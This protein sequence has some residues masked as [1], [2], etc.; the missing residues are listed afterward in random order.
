[1]AYRHINLV[2]VRAFFPIDL[3][4]Y[5]MVIEKVSYLRIFKRFMGHDMT[6]MAGGIP[7]GKKDRFVFPDRFLE[8]LISPGIPLDWIFSMLKQI[9]TFLIL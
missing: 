7:D 9:R 5:I 8:S 3:Y 6:P 4:S 1:L 2:D